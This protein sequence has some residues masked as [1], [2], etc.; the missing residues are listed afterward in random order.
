MVSAQ[1]TS[2]CIVAWWPPVCAS[3]WHSTW[4]LHTHSSWQ[5][6]KWKSIG[7]I[8]FITRMPS[9]ISCKTPW[10]IV[11]WNRNALGEPGLI[12]V[13]WCWLP[14]VQV[15]RLLSDKPANESQLCA[16][17]HVAPTQVFIRLHTQ[18]SSYTTNPSATTKP[19]SSLHLF[20]PLSFCITFGDLVFYLI[21]YR[22]RSTPRKISSSW[23][24]I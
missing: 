17:I 8:R 16:V 23:A 13:M 3:L 14:V 5:G 1:E 19:A 18:H 7:I 15:S 6:R 24:Y 9:Y 12:L 10:I 4:L 21:S 20:I 22:L 2:I 11:I